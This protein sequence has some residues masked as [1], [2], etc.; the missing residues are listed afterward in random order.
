MD[1][2]QGRNWVILRGGHRY[3]CNRKD[4]IIHGLSPSEKCVAPL[5]RDMSL[6][7]LGNAVGGMRPQAPSPVTPLISGILFSSIGR[8]VR[9]ALWPY[10]AAGPTG[11]QWM[12]FTFVLQ[13]V[14][15][16]PCI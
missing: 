13:H 16:H 12:Q 15:P 3:I 2:R 8:H 11:S 7:K 6:A 9:L 10:P 4:E 1:K 5:Y 14:S